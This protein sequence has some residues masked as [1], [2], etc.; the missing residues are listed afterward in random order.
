MRAML[1]KSNQTSLSWKSK[2]SIPR[3]IAIGKF[4]FKKVFLKIG[5]MKFELIMEQSACFSIPCLF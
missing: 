1:I 3:Y 5:I 2:I 4:S